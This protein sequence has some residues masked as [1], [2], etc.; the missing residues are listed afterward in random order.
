MNEV[1]SYHMWKIYADR[2][3]GVAIQSTYNKLCTSFDVYKNNDVFIGTIS[4]DENT[5]KF[6]N[7]FYP[8]MYKRPYFESDKELRA[9]VLNIWKNYEERIYDASYLN[10]KGAFIPVDIDVLIEKV[11]VSSGTTDNDLDKIITISKEYLMKKPIE[12]SKIDE[13]PIS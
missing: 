13:M 6:A 2:K 7:S 4:Y 8:Y 12:R 1:E 11:V 10:Q 3:Y 5:I 9:I